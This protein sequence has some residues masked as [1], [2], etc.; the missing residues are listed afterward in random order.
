MPSCGEEKNRASGVV[1][2]INLWVGGYVGVH[3]TQIIKNL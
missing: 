3:Y 2:K 1:G